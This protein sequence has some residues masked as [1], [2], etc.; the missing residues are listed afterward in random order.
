MGYGVRICDKEG[1]LMRAGPCKGCIPPVR[2]P[3]CH[4]ECKDYKEWKSERDKASN[5]NKMDNHIDNTLKSLKM[6]T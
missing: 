3:G 6:R 2:H 5:K 1:L 4:D